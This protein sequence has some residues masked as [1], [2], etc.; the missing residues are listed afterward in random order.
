MN[1][2]VF[3]T[4]LALVALYACDTSRPSEPGD[5]GPTFEVANVP[6]SAARI[7][8]STVVAGSFGPFA[9][10]FTPGE[11]AIVSYELDPS[12]PDR[13]PAPNAGFYFN[14]TLALTFEFPDR[15]LT[16][17][18]AQ[19]NV[20]TFDNT[21]N[22]D[23]Q[24]FIF[25]SVNQNNSMLGG[26]TVT[27]TELDFIGTTSMLSSDALPSS[28][29]SHVSQISVHFLTSSGFTQLL[30]KPNQAP[31]LAIVPPPAITVASDVGRCDA[32]VN[33]GTPTTAGGT[34]PIAL[35]ATPAGPYSVG[36]TTVTWTATDASGTTASATQFVTVRDQELPSVVTPPNVSTVTDP[37]KPTA[38]VSPGVATATDNCPGV[39]VTGA[40]N[41]GQAL[42]APYPVGQTI[43]TWTATDA[44][45]NKANASQS[46]TVADKEPPTLGVP[47]DFAVN[48]TSPAGAVVTYKVIASDNVAV[49]SLTCSPESGTTF[50]VGTSSVTCVASD[51]SGNRASAT[52]HVTVLSVQA[53]IS[54]LETSVT[55]LALS[56]GTT[57][58]LLAKL[59]GALAAANAGDVATACASL[60]DFIN[61]TRAQAGKKISISDA[62]TLSAAAQRMRAVLGC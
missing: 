40:R 34:P 51:P 9:G 24:V 60:Q 16:I 41:D 10:T 26:E 50:P 19:G 31:P 6:V 18:F 28:I 11:V 55:S 53:Q 25:G 47:A 43:I 29:L 56:T 35:A 12:V 54:N 15:G 3:F 33:L 7:S 8:F 32:Q 37:G 27:N 13:N 48:A 17:D 2:R 38:S 52:F 46:V 23:D 49:A 57:T 39:T 20:Q 30:L 62:N 45:A 1:L 42:N 5:V 61:E 4:P 14:A 59:N 58:S 36:N 22:P 21:A 44:S